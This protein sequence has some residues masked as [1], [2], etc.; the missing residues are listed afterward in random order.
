M[1]YYYVKNGGTATGDAGRSATKLTTSFS[2]MGDSA[3]YDSLY[4]V[5]TGGV[6]TTAPV[7]GDT[8]CVS[9]LHDK[10]YTVSTVVGIISGVPVFSVDD[11]AASSYVSGAWE[12]TVAAVNLTPFMTA[13][14]EPSY[15]HSKGVSFQCGNDLF[16][17]MKNRESLIED[18]QLWSTNKDILHNHDGQRSVYKAVEVKI[19]DLNDAFLVGGASAVMFSGCTWMQDNN[20]LLTS[21][22]A[23]GLRAI[24]NSCDLSLCTNDIVDNTAV[25]YNIADIELNRCKIGAGLVGISGASKYTLK[26]KG[27]R[28][29]SCDVGDGYHYFRHEQ[30]FGMNSEE[31]SIYR[32]DGATYDGTNGFSVELISESSANLASPCYAELAS[33]YIDTDDFTTTVTVTVHFAVDGSTTALNDDEFYIEVKYPDGADNALGVVSS[34]KAKPLAVGAAPVTEAGLWAGLG[35]TNKQ[36]SLSKELTIGT[37]EG[38]IASGLVEVKA[39]LSKASQVAFVCPQVEFS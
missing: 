38:T 9:N 12:R 39:Y 23:G 22:G 4:D 6:P 25:G 24:F 20:A 11:N 29:S 36:M 13:T 34:T 30:E 15:M 5:F 19:S 28:F 8:V 31:T 17:R 16:V 35:G 7:A 37:T 27:I 2:T 21:A 18:C 10:T 14:T 26:N 1:S 3:Y 33:Q 32:T